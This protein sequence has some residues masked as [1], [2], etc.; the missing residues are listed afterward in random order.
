MRSKEAIPVPLSE[1]VST[2]YVTRAIPG[3]AG[4]G[5]VFAN[6]DGLVSEGVYVVGWAGKGASGTIPTTRT[7]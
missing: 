3:L 4:D 5:G 7:G 2:N 6:K 1:L